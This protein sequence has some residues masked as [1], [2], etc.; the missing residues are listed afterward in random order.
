GARVS[1]GGPRGAV[2]AP[3]GGGLILLVGPLTDVVRARPVTRVPDRCLS[4]WFGWLHDNRHLV[5]FREE[6]G[7]EN[8]QA[9]G[10]DLDTGELRT[11]A[12]GP[13]VRSYVQQVSPR[14]PSE[15]LIAHNQRDSRF[16]DIYRVNAATAESTL[17]E[18]ND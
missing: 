15:L 4:F 3:V 12:P 11:L 10:V 2:L 8:W 6:G 17:I 13:G 5:V 1:P 18:T 7:D 14:F 16:F 9:H